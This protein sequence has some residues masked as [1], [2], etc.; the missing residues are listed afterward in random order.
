VLMALSG[1]VIWFLRKS[2]MMYLRLHWRVLALA[3]LAYLFALTPLFRLGFLT[4]TGSTIDGLSYAVRSEYLQEAPLVQPQVPPG[5][6]FYG[7]V[8][9][10]ISVL[11]VGDVYSVGVIGFLSGLRSYELLTCVAALFYALV[12]VTVHVLSRRV[13]LLKARTALLASGLAA[14]HNLLLW[15]VHDNFLSQSIGMSVFPLVLAFGVVAARTRRWPETIGFSFLLAT[16]FSVYPVYAVLAGAT[17]ALCVAWYLVMSLIRSNRSWRVELTERFRWVWTAMLLL[18]LANPVGMWRSFAELDF[19]GKLLDPETSYIVGG[20]NIFVFPSIAEIF[21][22]VAHGSAVYGLDAWQLPDSL[23]AIWIGV[24][25]LVALIGLLLVPRRLRGPAILLLGGTVA[26]A[27]FQRFGVDAPNGY[28]YG[29]FKAVSLVAILT[30]PFLA[31]GFVA[32]L[33][34]RYLRGAAGVLLLALFSVNSLNALWTLDFILRDRVLLDADL[35]DASKGVQT[36][37][38]GDW[39]LVDMQPSLRQHWMGYLLKEQHLQYRERLFT[40]NVY[41]PVVPPPTFRYSLVERSLDAKRSLQ[42]IDEPWYNPEMSEEV[43]GNDRYVLRKRIDFVVSEISVPAADS[44]WNPG[45]V[46]SVEMAP[47]DSRFVCSLETGVSLQSELD[48]ASS[49]VQ[50]FVLS[51]SDDATICLGDDYVVLDAGVW[52]VD[53]AV[54][55]ST[56]LELRNCGSTPVSIHSLQ[57]LAADTGSNNDALEATKRPDGVAFVNQTLVGSELIYDVVLVPPEGSVAVYRLGLHMIEQT[58]SEI[59]GVWALDFPPSESV[60]VGQLRIDLVDRT[61]QGYVNGEDVPVELGPFDA[62]IGMMEA[63]VVWWRLG[64]PSYLSLHRATTFQH[65]ASDVDSI[66]LLAP[67]PPTLLIAQ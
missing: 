33:R 11:R 28:P 56:A 52:T 45:D 26:L 9:S 36:H 22:L 65:T 27:L 41:I 53:L 60:D 30:L 54:A 8:A 32:L 37:L 18:A 58:H 66:E 49:T 44:W 31:A 10:Q 19:V 21:G 39:V 35:I 47:E 40:Q 42:V 6:P 43:W 4:T 7:W 51:P 2:P 25:M 57:A 3:A 38:A 62:E 23:L 17:C 46:V 12:P 61:A 15:A 55:G 59:F 64:T 1:P 50:V 34:V 20:G 5:Q 13:L 29:Y 14:V 67:I 63:Q 48:A 24:L 16:L